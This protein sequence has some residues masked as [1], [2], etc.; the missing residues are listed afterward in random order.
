MITRFIVTAFGL[1]YFPVAPGTWASLAAVLAAWGIVDII[2]QSGL[3]SVT[4]LSLALGIWASRKYVERTGSKDPSEIVIDE[5]GGMWLSLVFVPKIW[6]A[7][8]LAF[9]AFRLFD[10]VKPW[11]AS[12][13]DKEV[14]GGL[15]VMADDFVAAL[16]ALIVVHGTLYLWGAG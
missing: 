10:I 3:I 2:G 12:F 8:G 5:V 14:E 16:Y 6:W 11:P 9:A 13:F 4:A 15:G 1:G 7:Y